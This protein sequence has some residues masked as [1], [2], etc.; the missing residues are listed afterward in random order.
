MNDNS[1]FI[2]GLVSAGLLSTI[3]L[4]LVYI[5]WVTV[6]KIACDDIYNSLFKGFRS[7]AIELLFFIPLLIVINRFVSVLNRRE[8]LV[9]VAVF[10]SICLVGFLYFFYDYAEIICN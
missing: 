9:S 10:V 2:K 6:P 3:E 1:G 8:H 4:L 7:L 5:L